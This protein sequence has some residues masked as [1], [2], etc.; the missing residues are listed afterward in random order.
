MSKFGRARMS[1]RGQVTIPKTIRDNWGLSSGDE[2]GLV[3]DGQSL[4]LRRIEAGSSAEPLPAVD[5][6]RAAAIAEIK[7]LRQEF[8]GI[9]GDELLATSRRELEMS[10]TRCQ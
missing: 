6:A 3:F 8:A 1:A 9:D 7:R 4:V 10:A 2:F 5:A